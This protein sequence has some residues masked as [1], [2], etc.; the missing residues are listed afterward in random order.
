MKFST[1]SGKQIELKI[2]DA[3]ATAYIAGE[4]IGA[5]ESSANRELGWHLKSGDIHITVLDKDQKQV[6]LFLVSYLKDYKLND[7]EVALKK[8]YDDYNKVINANYGSN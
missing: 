7:R 5:V 2:D 6:K 8:Y 1:K 4:K 3:V